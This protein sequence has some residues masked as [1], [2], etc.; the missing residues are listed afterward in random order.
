MDA[1]FSKFQ[2][3]EDACMMKLITNVYSTVLGAYFDLRRVVDEGVDIRE[4]YGLSPRE[5]IENILTDIRPLVRAVEELELDEE[6]HKLSTIA[7]LRY[8]TDRYLE[9]RKAAM[10]EEYGQRCVALERVLDDMQRKMR[11]EMFDGIK[12]VKE[13]MAERVNTAVEKAVRK[14]EERYRGRPCTVG[15]ERK[16]RL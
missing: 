12:L 1:Q 2:K 14:T 16:V 3:A 4:D 7:H 15:N 6:G 8:D 5:F 11:Q 13:E 9:N 10:E